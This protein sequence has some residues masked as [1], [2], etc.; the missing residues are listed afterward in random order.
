M[1]KEV[2]IDVWSKKSL[3]VSLLDLDLKQKW[4]RLL[5]SVHAQW[6]NSDNSPGWIVPM[7]FEKELEDIVINNSRSDRKNNRD[8]VRRHSR[9]NSDDVVS[10]RQNKQN[11]D[12]SD[13][14]Y[15]RATSRRRSHS[16]RSDSDD[17]D[18]NDSSSDDELIQEVLAK[19]LQSEST[20][21]SIESEVIENSDDEDIVSCTRRMRHMY[22]VMQEQRRKIKHLEEIINK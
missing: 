15:H 9:V 8:S 12:D 3:I 16:S 5:S 17:D 1:P 13:E 2:D 14:E 7:S 21:K 10:G 18:Y 20:Q 4:S 19:K 22:T 11:N 6:N